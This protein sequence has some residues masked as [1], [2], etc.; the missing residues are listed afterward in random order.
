M[1]SRQ[2]SSITDVK[3]IFWDLRVINNNE[4]LNTS[5][6]SGDQKTEFNS[7]SVKHTIVIHCEFQKGSL[8][9]QILT[10]NGRGTGAARLFH[11]H[12]I[13]QEM[14]YTIRTRFLKFRKTRI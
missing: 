1:Q 11:I 9:F 8:R 14:G 12:H 3:N 4:W 13:W 7:S 5:I 2:D 6:M 10:W